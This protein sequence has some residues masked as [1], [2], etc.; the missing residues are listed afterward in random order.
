MASAEQ[1]YPDRRHAAEGRRLEIQARLAVDALGGKLLLVPLDVSRPGLRVLDSATAN[2][3]FLY[4]LRKELADPDSAELI[5]TD[6]LPYDTIGLPSNI[7]LSKQDIHAEWPEEWAGSF[8]LVHQRTTLTMTGT[9]ERAVAAVRRLV[10]L[11][12]PGGWVQLVD[13]WMPS[14][15]IQPDDLP[16]TKLAK[17]MHFGLKK[18]GFDPTIGYEAGEILAKAGEGLLQNVDS[19]TVVKVCGKGAATQELEEM[20]Y[21]QLQ[22]L[23]S[24]A[25][26]MLT[27]LPEEERPVP[28]DEFQNLLEDILAQAREGKATLN[29]SAAW[30]QRI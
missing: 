28:L 1:N 3:E 12:K 15:P 4:S 30:G 21:E 19:R 14:E 18:I 5:G 26:Y 23:H 17:V 6:I 9:R 16:A 8:D 27:R 24:A 13:G 7:K 20:G 10:L 11:T 2:G 25:T 22:G 29:W